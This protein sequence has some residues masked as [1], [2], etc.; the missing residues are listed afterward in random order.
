MLV[1]KA[2]A[3]ARMASMAPL[4][5]TCFCDWS[6]SVICNRMSQEIIWRS[7]LDGMVVIR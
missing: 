3:A 6:S 1:G 2:R 7:R 5:P 4:S